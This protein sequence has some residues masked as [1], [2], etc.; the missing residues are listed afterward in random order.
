VERFVSLTAAGVAQGAIIALVALGFLLI[1][2]ATGVVNFAQ[3]ELV[4]LGAY[5]AVWASTDNDMPLLA[6]AALA[7]VALFAVGVLLERFAYAPLRGRSIHVVVISTL[8]AALVIRAGLLLWQGSAPKRL[9]SPFGFEVF[10]LAGARIPQQNLVIVGV[11]AACIVAMILVFALTQFGRQLRALAVDRVTAQLQGIRVV[12]MSM[13]A[14]GLSAA[15]SG[16]AGVLIGPTRQI[17][18]TLGFGPM[19]YAFAAAILGSMG[20][21]GG[22]A[23]GALALGLVQQLGAGYLSPDYAEIYPFVLMLAVIAVRPQGL[24]GSETGARL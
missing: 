5:I 15:L 18:I 19:L 14:F 4:T 16:L 6:G 13:L 23:I 21:L 9:A 12:R 1:Y 24:L 17:T 11:T 2:K 20:R 10:E 8:G 22:V 7:V 3:G